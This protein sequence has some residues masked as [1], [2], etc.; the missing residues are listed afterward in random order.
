MGRSRFPCVRLY[1]QVV[2]MVKPR[3]P[4]IQGTILVESNSDPKSGKCQIIWKTPRIR[5]ANS[6]FLPFIILGR[7]KPLQAGSS[8]KP[9]KRRRN[10]NVPGRSER[11][12]MR[13]HVGASVPSRRFIPIATLV[14]ITGRSKPSRTTRC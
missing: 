1:I 10:M 14:A 8:P 6:A 3:T 12:G 2:M 5:L 7:A 11:D 4:N 13:S 9:I